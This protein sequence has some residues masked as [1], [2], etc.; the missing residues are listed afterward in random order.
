M[1][2]ANLIHG[3]YAY[4][5]LVKSFPE[6]HNLT[7]EEITPGVV[8]QWRVSQLGKGLKPVT[9]N[10]QLSDLRACLN[11]AKDI[12]EFPTTPLDKVKPSKVDKSPKVRYLTADEEMRL[13]QA[14]DEREEAICSGRESGNEW[15]EVRGYDQLSDLR[16]LAF[17]DHLK[18]AI[19]V[20]LN[21]GMRR[22]EL[23]KLKW[24]CVSFE[25]R[26]LT[27]VGTTFKTG[28]TRH[29]PLNDEALTTLKWKDQPGVKSAYVFGDHTGEPLQGM[30]T[31]W[32]NL[33][34]KRAKIHGFRWH[35]L[36][37]D[38]ASKLVMA[39]VDLNTVRELLGHSDYK[40][41]LKYAHLAPEVKQKAVDKLSQAKVAT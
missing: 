29:I 5:T 22:G 41:T 16:K 11:R 3:E 28:K 23:L 26:T 39:G 7:L 30:K 8:E 4:T 34:S 38:F 40:M 2:E 12:W 24:E 31:S 6:M 13:R 32:E 20:S 10:R 35:D 21:T 33:L 18:P 17:V 15:R 14:L 27:V 1:V 9:V 37:H 25:R 36:R 19:L